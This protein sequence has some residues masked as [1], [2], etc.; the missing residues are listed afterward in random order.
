MP[1]FD[2]SA[3]VDKDAK[4]SKLTFWYDKD[5]IYGVRAFYSMSNGSDIAGKE[6]LQ[7]ENK[8]KL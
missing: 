2:D 8:A 3:L 4:I 1:E 6:N 5:Q 7:V